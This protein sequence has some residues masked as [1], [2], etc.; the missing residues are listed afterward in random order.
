MATTNSPHLLGVLHHGNHPS[1]LS[2]DDPYISTSH[3]HHR[4]FS[5]KEVGEGGYMHVCESGEGSATYI[6]GGVYIRTTYTVT[7]HENMQC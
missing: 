5:S 4:T 7:E 1:A 6:V 3:Y 2:C